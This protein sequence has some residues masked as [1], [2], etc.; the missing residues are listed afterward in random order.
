MANTDNRKRWEI[1]DYMLSSNGVAADDIFLEWKNK[2]ILPKSYSENKSL[3]EQYELTLRQDLYKFRNIYKDSGLTGPLLDDN[4]GLMGD[5][6]KKFYRY[7]RKGWSIIPLILSKFTRSEWHA[8]DQAMEKLKKDLPKAMSEQIDFLVMSRL[9]SMRGRTKT[10]DWPDVNNKLG[11]E[12]LSTLHDCIIKKQPVRIEFSL[13]GEKPEN[14]LLHPYM[15][16]EY[17]GRWYCL[18]YREDKKEIWPISVDRVTPGSIK[19]E[20]VQYKKYPGLGSP[21][22]HF[23]NII[24]VT[25]IYNE[26]T[27][28]DYMVADGEYEVRLGIHSYRAW[29][30]L[31]TNPIHHSQA[32]FQDFD[33]NKK[34]G[35]V[36]IRV[37]PNIEMYQTILRRGRDICIETPL[38]ARQNLKQMIDDI[39]K[40]YK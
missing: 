19:A 17:N 31:I 27:A 35:S 13:F 34:Y 12:M 3:R 16:K 10:V 7:S 30:Y 4:G 36:I 32:I 40:L 28:R 9:N 39:A 33:S 8:L 11:F 24:G 15:L 14:F 6:R 1:L 25:K 5:G 20:N 21:E 18:G 38:F 2:G 22:F 29:M 26:T 37:I 23:D